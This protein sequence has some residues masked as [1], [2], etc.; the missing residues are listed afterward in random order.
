MVLLQRNVDCS[1]E[2]ANELL[3]FLFNLQPVYIPGV[4]NTADLSHPAV[5]YPDAE[6][7]VWCLNTD[8]FDEPPM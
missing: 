2:M 7:I 8:V 5:S 6:G 1:Q 4:S 3:Y